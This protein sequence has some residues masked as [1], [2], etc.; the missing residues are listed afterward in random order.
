MNQNYTDPMPFIVRIR[1]FLKQ[2]GYEPSELEKDLLMHIA[3][4][5][6]IAN[7]ATAV[8]LH[9]NAT[10]PGKCPRDH[11]DEVYSS[12]REDGKISEDLEYYDAEQILTILERFLQHRR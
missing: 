6:Q 9:Y 10:H 4:L 1:D 3:A 5:Q 8:A 7:K 12:L 11:I 2:K